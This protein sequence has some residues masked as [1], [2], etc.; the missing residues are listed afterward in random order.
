M[1]PHGS[2]QVVR[3]SHSIRLD[4]VLRCLDD[5]K[6]LNNGYLPSGCGRRVRKV[7]N[8]LKPSFVVLIKDLSGAW[9]TIRG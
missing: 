1:K 6:G 5:L 3:K 4:P 7:A 2:I 9:V 8:D